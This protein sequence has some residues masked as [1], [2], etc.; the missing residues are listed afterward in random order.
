MNSI[1]TDEIAREDTPEIRL[2]EKERVQV[3]RWLEKVN[4]PSAKVKRTMQTDEG[5]TIEREFTV[6]RRKSVVNNYICWF[7]LVEG[8]GQPLAMIVG[9]RNQIIIDPR[10]Q[11]IFVPQ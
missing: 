11:S 7:A 6:I 4:V 10:K 9:P 5:L 8:S 1:T 2:S 3:E